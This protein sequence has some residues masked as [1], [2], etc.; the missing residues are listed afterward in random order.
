MTGSYAKA[1]TEILEI[2]RYLPKEEYNKIPKEKIEF[3]K[4]NKDNNYNYQFDESKTLEEQTISR[5]ANA[6]IISLFRDFFATPMQ[7]DKLDKILKQNEIKYQ[8]ELNKKYN[9][10]NIFKQSETKVTSDENSTL[11]EQKSITVYKEPIFTKI[12]NWFKNLFFRK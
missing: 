2:L 1:Y 11:V 6:I 10:D 5:E 3:Y 8:E 9:P 7:Q 12:V 4:K